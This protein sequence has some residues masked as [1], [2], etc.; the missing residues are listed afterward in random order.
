MNGLA[1]LPEAIGL[2]LHLRANAVAQHAQP[3]FPPPGV[4]WNDFKR[5][6]RLCEKGV[7][8]ERK[9]KE[10]MYALLD[11][12]SPGKYKSGSLTNEDTYITALADV[13]DACKDSSPPAVDV[14][15]K[16]HLARAVVVGETKKSS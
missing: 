13:Y 1:P 12:F 11:A 2:A 4:W 7:F 10:M 5:F 16:G 6:A 9:G 8:N 15:M 14:S 3:H